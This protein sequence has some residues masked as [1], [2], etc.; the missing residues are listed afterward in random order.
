MTKPAAMLTVL[1]LVAMMTAPVQAGDTPVASP[2]ATAAIPLEISA[3]KGLVWDR[4]NR[5]YTAKGRAEVRQ[6]EMQV[7][8]DQIIARYA[9]EDSASDIQTV[10]AEGNVTLSQ[11]PYNA[12][13]DRADYDVMQ[14]RAVLT[15]ANLR[16]VT[17]DERLTAQDRITYDAAAGQMTAEGGAVMT[18]GTD[19]LS[20]STLIATFA[21]DAAGTRALDTVTAEGGVSITTPRET[22][23]GKRGVYRAATQQAELTGGV[24]IVQGPN[25]LEG[26]RATVDMKTGVSQ[27]FGAGAGDGRVRGVF[28]PKSNKAAPVVPPAVASKPV[29]A[30]PEAA[31]PP[32]VSAPA[33]EKP[34]TAPLPVAAPVVAPAPEKPA[35]AVSAPAVSALPLTPAAT[36]P[37]AAPLPDEPFAVPTAETKP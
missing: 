32:P 10:T 37:P 25:R 26:T 20:A 27:L 11:P 18:R 16:I 15:G 6:G 24:V 7:T 35:A 33:P 5:S 36:A 1:L 13:G 3:D 30:Q 14:G 9:G 28:Y 19:R 4:A 34:A 17:P 12:Y 2:A 23:T 22:I 31:P 29:V 21:T 8:A